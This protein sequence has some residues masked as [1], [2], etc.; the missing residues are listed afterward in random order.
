MIT[1]SNLTKRFGSFEALKDVSFS[2][3]PGQAVALWGPNGAGKTT[4]IKCILGLLG[5][6]GAIT[7]NRHDVRRRGKQARNS[8]GYVPQELRFYDDWRVSEFLRF[9]SQ[10][11]QA[12]KHRIPVVLAEV[13]LETHDRKRIGEL[14]GGMKQRLALAAALLA[15][16]PLLVLDEITSNLDRAARE[17]FLG[18]LGGLKQR[19]KTILFTSHRL[20][21]VE[22]LADRVLV[23]ESGRLARECPPDELVGQ[24]GL[25]AHLKIILAPPDIESAVR[26]LRHHGL[27][28]RGNG[29]GVEVRTRQDAKAAPIRMLLNAGIAVD[30]FELE[31]ERHP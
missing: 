17:A 12:P 30:N 20:D 15:E 7:V 14:S 21:E 16:P 26:I 1:V 2:V 6:E 11:K 4:A 9:C 19:G 24:V 13:G 25:Q 28:A 27:A 3:E 10:L 22:R 8:L 31:E 29:M 18:L 5:C 23:L